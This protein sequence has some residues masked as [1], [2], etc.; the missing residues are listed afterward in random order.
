M[1]VVLKLAAFMT[2]IDVLP[3]KLN[4]RYR[5]GNLATAGLYRIAVVDK[6]AGW[7][8]ET[9]QETVSPSTGTT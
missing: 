8:G 2:R 9:G 1:L 4:S 6:R 7:A 5:T 3:D